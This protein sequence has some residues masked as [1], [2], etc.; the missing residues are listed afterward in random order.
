MNKKCKVCKKPIKRKYTKCF[1]CHIK[2]KKLLKDFNRTWKK[3]GSK[4]NYNKKLKKRL[5]I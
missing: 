4:K 3:T 1:E 5:K 2:D